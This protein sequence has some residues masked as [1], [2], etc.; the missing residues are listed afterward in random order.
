MKQKVSDNQTTQSI[1][2][3]IQLIK[4]PIIRN[5]S[6]LVYTNGV[7]YR[8]S[9]YFHIFY[10]RKSKVFFE[11]VLII[12]KA[13]CEKYCV[14]LKQYNELS[15]ESLEYHTLTYAIKCIPFHY[16][17]YYSLYELQSLVKSTFDS[18][19]SLII[20]PERTRKSLIC[21]RDP[22]FRDD[23]SIKENNLLNILSTLIEA[24]ENDPELLQEDLVKLVLNK[25]KGISKKTIIKLIKNN[26]L[27]VMKKDTKIINKQLR[28]LT[29]YNEGHSQ[30]EIAKITGYSK[31]N[32][33]KIIHKL[34]SADVL[35]IN[36]KPVNIK[37]PKHQPTLCE[38][39][40]IHYQSLVNAR[41]SK[42]LV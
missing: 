5:E 25:Y 23:L 16:L 12:L 37:E 18:R 17:E 28:V 35:I 41:K 7:A 10:I 14:I 38:A 36:L 3:R 20:K 33:S 31:G 13:V 22:L 21:K 26:T 9:N 40:K 2:N 29:L 24:L 1:Y 27:N 42:S 39:L 19:D 15:I 34:T 11:N 30:T 6:P 4:C 8:D 32:V